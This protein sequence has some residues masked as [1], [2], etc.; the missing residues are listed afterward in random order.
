MFFLKNIFLRQHSHSRHCSTFSR[1]ILIYSRKIFF[2]LNQPYLVFASLPS[3][4]LAF[5]SLSYPQLGLQSY[6]RNY[7][8][9]SS[10]IYDHKIY[11]RKCLQYRP[12]I[13]TPNCGITFMIG[14]DDNQLRLSVPHNHNLQF[15]STDHTIILS[16]HLAFVLNFRKTFH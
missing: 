15:Y 12:Q 5:P 9:N 2:L 3:P 11:D 7:A 1:A 8:P 14:I 4:S 16:L 6:N 13:D 10:V